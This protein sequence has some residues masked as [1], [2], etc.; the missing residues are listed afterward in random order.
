MHVVGDD[1]RKRDLSF[2]DEVVNV[3]GKIS[4]EVEEEKRKEKEGE[5]FDKVFENVAFPDFC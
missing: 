4:K 3:R 5:E 2:F 1:L